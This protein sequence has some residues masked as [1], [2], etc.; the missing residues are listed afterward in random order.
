MAR[1][2]SK[3]AVV[4]IIYLSVFVFFWIVFRGEHSSGRMYDDKGR[5]CLGVTELLE[6]TRHNSAECE[7]NEAQWAVQ[8]DGTPSPIVYYAPEEA[9]CISNDG[10]GTV[11]LK[12]CSGEPN[13]MWLYKDN[14]VVAV[15]SGLNEKNPLC[16]TSWSGLFHGGE[17]VGLR[18][19]GK[20][21]IASQTWKFDQDES[22]FSF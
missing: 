9:L 12:P 19:C 22:V 20:R 11:S 5:T 21:Q 7:N 8:L 10:D 6:I 14:R 1:V 15:G 18:A 3:A 2:R 4:A 16:L 13:Q 17:P